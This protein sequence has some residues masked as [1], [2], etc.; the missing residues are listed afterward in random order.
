MDNYFYVGLAKHISCPPS[1]TQTVVVEVKLLLVDIILRPT[2]LNTFELVSKFCQKN[3][4]RYMNF[5]RRDRDFCLSESRGS[6]R[7]R[8]YFFLNL[9]VRD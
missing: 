9:R 3:T 4:P 7:D 8:E 2:F 5:S 6:R 1:Q